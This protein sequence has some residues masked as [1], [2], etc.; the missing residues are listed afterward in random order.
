M[1]GRLRNYTMEE[2]RARGAEIAEKEIK[3]FQKWD[4]WN[5]KKSLPEHTESHWS[6]LVEYVDCVPSPD[7]WAAYKEGYMQKWKEFE[8]SK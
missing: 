2:F 5:C 4:K 7:A 1:M 3:Y 8:E 6:E